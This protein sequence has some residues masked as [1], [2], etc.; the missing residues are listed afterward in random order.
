MPRIPYSPVPSVQSTGAPEAYQRIDASPAAFGAGVAAA[1]GNLGK[2]IGDVAEAVDHHVVQFQKM[3]NTAESNDLDMQAAEQI[4]ELDSWYSSLEG[5]QKMDALPAYQE[6]IKGIRSNIIGKAS[7]PAVARD[8]DNALRRSVGYSLINAGKSAG[9]AIKQYERQATVSKVSLLSDQA[10]REA[11]DNAFAL[12][13][14][15]TNKTLDQLAVS[16]GWDPDT[17]KLKKM[18]ITG[19]SWS[20]RLTTMS[21]TEPVR[22]QKLLEEHKADM[23]VNVQEQLTKVVRQGI[24]QY[25]T[26]N[27][28]DK[29][30]TLGSYSEYSKTLKGSESGNNPNAKAS[31]SSA[32]GLYQFTKETWA[33]QMRKHPELGLTVEGRTDQEQSEKANEAFT[34]ENAKILASQGISTSGKNLKMMH[35]M[36]QAGG[37]AFL[38][39]LAARPDGDAAKAFPEAA[40]ANKS[41]FDDKDTGSPR[42]IKEVYN[43]L[44]AKFSGENVAINEHSSATDLKAAIEVGRAEMNKL[45][46]GDLVAQDAVEAR[47]TQK[48]NSAKSV[49]KDTEHKQFIAL[50]SAALDP[51]TKPTTLDQLFAADPNMR[52]AYMTAEPSRQQAINRQLAMNEKGYDPPMNNK[53]LLRRQELLGMSV[54]KPAEF[55]KMDI[56]GEDLPLAEKKFFMDMQVKKGVD[57]AQGG[58]KDIGIQSALSIGAPYIKAAGIERTDAN[59]DLENPARYNTFIGALV[60]KLQAAQ[61]GGNKLNDKE[62]LQMVKDLLVEQQ[63]VE[64]GYMPFGLSDSNVPVTKFEAAEKLRKGEVMVP[65]AAVTQIL[66]AAKVQ[67]KATPLPS[68]IIEIYIA[69]KDRLDAA[70]KGN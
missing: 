41:I 59:N 1:M 67:G 21:V 26:R 68:Q 45:L 69:N 2:G 62:K 38:A 43:K 6:R 24:I 14:A 29:A 13:V 63:Y 16:E 64:P 33:D 10:G 54:N 61:D 3:A 65:R 18:E 52:T 9:S 5:K 51:K 70:A 58:D 20:D 47:I 27:I 40:A 19:K 36:G 56:V 8:T 25:E 42:T 22:A 15:D 34:M 30:V 39:Q 31:T 53:R 17:T 32:T 35:F 57:G 48:Y 60:D 66:E 7:N 46:P 44:T 4:G 12:R 55:A 49:I 23:P 50:Q 37:P 28:A 11:D